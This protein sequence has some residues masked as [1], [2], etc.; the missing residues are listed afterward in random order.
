MALNT[1]SLI[2][3]SMTLKEDLLKCCT[4]EISYGLCKFI[5]EVC[6]PN[7]EKYSPDSIFYLCLGIQQVNH[8]KKKKKHKLNT[9]SHVIYSLFDLALVVH[10]CSTCLRTIGWRTSLQTSSTPNSAMKWAT[11]SEG[12]NQLFC[13][14]VSNLRQKCVT[15]LFC[16]CSINMSLCVQVT[17]IL[18]WRR[19]ICG[20][21]SSWGRFHPVCCSTRC[22]TSSLSTS[23]TG[24]WSSTA[25]SLSA[26]SNATLEDKPTTKCPS[27]VSIPRKRTEAQVSGQSYFLIVRFLLI[28]FL[29]SHFV[30]FRWC[31][32]EEEGRWTAKGAKNTAEF[33]Q[34]S[35]LSCQAVRVLS[36]KMVRRH[37]V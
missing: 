15:S 24:Q 26:T 32:C 28:R 25:A 17:F 14:V 18:V 2:A 29:L 1:S 34:S 9:F 16:C 20:T 7:G 11:Y 30:Q 21:V 8:G 6:R 35:L 22:S 19:S 10:V 12:G 23:T 4:A 31:P 5:S 27:C 13:L 3:R 33:R 37:F 36:L